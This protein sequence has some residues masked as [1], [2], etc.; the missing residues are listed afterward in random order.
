MRSQGH[1]HRGRSAWASSPDL[2]LGVVVAVCL[3]VQAVVAKEVLDVRLD[4]FS[5]FAALWV[6]I[7]YLVTDRH[8][9]PAARAFALV[10]IAVTAAV[11]GLYALRRRG[12]PHGHLE[13]AA[14]IRTRSSCSWRCSAAPAPAGASTSSTA[15]PPDEAV[16]PAGGRA[17]GGHASRATSMAHPH[18]TA[19]PPDAHH[20]AQRGVCWCSTSRHPSGRRT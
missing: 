5:Q 14:R 12:R 1:P 17:P 20:P 9:R 7:A 3:L 13:R 16:R 2:V 10:A 19:E 8:D 6:Y 18:H 11:L 4:Y 15:W